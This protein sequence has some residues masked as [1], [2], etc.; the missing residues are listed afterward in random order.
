MSY[1]TAAVAD[2]PLL[3][4]GNDFSKTDIRAALV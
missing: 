2:L 3:F 1:A 4:I